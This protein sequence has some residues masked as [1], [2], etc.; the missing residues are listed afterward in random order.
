MVGG[1]GKAGLAVFASEG[2]FG[3]IPKSVK[4]GM[5]GLCESTAVTVAGTNSQIP[6]CPNS[7]QTG[8]IY[9]DGL[10]YNEDGSTTQRWIC[11]CCGQRF[12]NKPLKSNDTLT[13]SRQICA[14][15]AKNLVFTAEIK[16][17]VGDATIN[18]DMQGLLVKFYSYIE[19]EAY[20][21]EN[22]YPKLIKRLIL[23]GADLRDPESV[24]TII[25]KLKYTNKAGIVVNVKNGT[26][27][28]Y[29]AAYGAFAAMMKI[30]WSNPGYKQEE[31]EVYVPYESELDTLI[32]SAR[33]QRMAAY[34]QTLKE[35]FADPS[36][37]LRIRWID[38]DFKANTIKIN[39]PVKN[40]NTGTQQVSSK[41]LSMLS[42]LPHT[43]ERVFPTTYVNISECYRALRKHVAAV[44]QDPR[45]LSIELRGF[46]HWGGTKIAFDT[47]GNVLVVKKILRHKSV[48]STM[49]YIGKIDFKPDE[50][51]TTAATTV[52][53]I[54]ALG[55][56]GWVEYSVV[57]VGVQEIHCFK[58]PKRFGSPDIGVKN[59]DLGLNT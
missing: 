8:K 17:V 56:N 59:P 1:E 30:E 12:S 3:D 45:F 24:K 16:T 15:E 33:S 46:R 50:Y 54:L 18:P 21:E 49:K 11:T 9:R 26:K 6:T 37:A 22:D 53:E 47:N 39:F 42:A 41:L 5:D 52:E 7:C 44:Q 23:L 40:H 14:K 31:I 20:S 32:T 34:L 55:S 36:E 48:K 13:K 25:A 51:E 38:I 43:H 19:K 28:L 2:I 57:K 58:K 35:T 27:M 29:C 10:R 4:A